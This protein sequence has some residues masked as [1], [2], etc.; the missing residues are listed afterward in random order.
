MSN[1]KA[2]HNWESLS[3]NSRDR[4][5]QILCYSRE[6]PQCKCCSPGFTNLAVYPKHLGRLLKKRF[7]CSTL[8]SLALG[9]ES[10][11]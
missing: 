7:L 5:I 4:Q 9:L 6:P 10:I 8:G 11:F 1:L 2:I 3:S